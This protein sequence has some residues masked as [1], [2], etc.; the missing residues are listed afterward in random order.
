MTETRTVY[1]RPFFE[2]IATDC[3]TPEAGEH[4][5]DAFDEDEFE[6][7]EY[8]YGCTKHGSRPSGDSFVYTFSGGP[9]CETCY[10]KIGELIPEW[11]CKQDNEHWYEQVE[12]LKVSL[13]D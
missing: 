12:R 4:V 10:L 2:V 5:Y 13:D 8:G 11:R 9:V 3:T 7:F 1:V 6:I